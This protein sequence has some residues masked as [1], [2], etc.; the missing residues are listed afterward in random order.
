MPGSVAGLALALEKYGSGKFTLA[1][2]L[3]PSIRLANDGI[4]V[5]DDIADTLAEG[6]GRL[7]NF[8]NSLKF[9]D[10]ADGTPLREGDMLIQKDL[11]ANAVGDRRARPARLL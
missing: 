9:L 10:N 8:S 2:L 6:R 7:S 3:Q 4:P 1:E 11:A 5:A